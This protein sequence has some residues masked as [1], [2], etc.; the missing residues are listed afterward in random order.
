[1]S[2][3]ENIVNRLGKIMLNKKGPSGKKGSAGMGRGGEQ[4][5]KSGKESA[6]GSKKDCD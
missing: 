5:A 6:S 3:A 4:A 1:M 2:K